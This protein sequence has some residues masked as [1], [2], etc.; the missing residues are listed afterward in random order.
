MICCLLDPAVDRPSPATDGSQSARP[1]TATPA[2]GAGAASLVSL[3]AA[4]IQLSDDFRFASGSPPN[5][6][7]TLI[8]RPIPMTM[9]Y[10]PKLTALI[11]VTFF[12]ALCAD[13]PALV[14]GGIPET[15]QPAVLVNT[16][17]EPIAPGKFQPTWESLSEYQVPEWFRD[18]KFGIWAHWG[19]QCQPED[20]DW[21]ARQHVSARVSARLQVPSR[22]LRPSVGIGFK[23]VIHTGRRRTGTRR[24][25]SRST[26]AR[27][28]IF[29]RAGEPPR[30]L[31]HSGT[32]SI[33]PGTP[34]T[35]VRRR[36]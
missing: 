14:A 27:R 16:Q 36:T 23:D 22:A 26:S 32:A 7:T 9:I 21:Y 17:T 15:A 8:Q 31:R 10:S 19:P 18:A 6:F 1:V 11:C 25:W 3:A 24:N 30:Q 20:G 5:F 34:S 2:S 4:G 35:S 13:A 33:S 29:H 12:F 28:E